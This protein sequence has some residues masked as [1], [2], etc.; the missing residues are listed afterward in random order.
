[1]F[2]KK[3]PISEEIHATTLSLPIS[4]SHKE[5]DILQVIKVLNRF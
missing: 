4:Y 2:K 1:M 5:K 3:Y